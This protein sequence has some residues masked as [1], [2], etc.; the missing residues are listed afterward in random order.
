VK[1]H[2]GRRPSAHGPRRSGALARGCYILAAGWLAACTTVPQPRSADEA[3]IAGRLALRIDSAESRGF[4]A[5]FRLQ[6]RPESGQLQLEGPLG[7]TMARI[8]WNQGRYTLEDSRGEQHFESL[9]ALARQGL[10]EPVP[11]EALFDWLRAKPWPGATWQARAD[12]QPG[13]EQLGWWLAT[14]QADEGTIVAERPAPP[15]MMLRIRLDT[16]VAPSAQARGPNPSAH[17]QAP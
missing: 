2:A 12:G 7:A 11:L 10:G 3:D 1:P 6:G 4:S 13:F 16:P 9:E 8:A 5:G 17:G 15:R 14:A